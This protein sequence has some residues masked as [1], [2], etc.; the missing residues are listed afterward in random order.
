MATKS[1]FNFNNLSKNDTTIQQVFE[2]NSLE[3]EE[4]K[5][6]EKPKEVPVPTFLKKISKF[7]L[8]NRKQIYIDSDQLG[9]KII[10][11]AAVCDYDI[12]DITNSILTNF[13]K[14]HDKE[15]KEFITQKTMEQWK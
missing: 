9:Q 10:A 6:E 7:K 1:T 12:K 3:K 2:K 11:L 5:R 8:D 4:S 15:I 14:Q 13:F